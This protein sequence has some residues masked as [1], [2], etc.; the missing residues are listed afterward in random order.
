MSE[1]ILLP[2]ELTVSLSI[3]HLRI[4]NNTIL[5]LYEQ[6]RKNVGKLK[7]NVIVLRILR[8]CI[9]TAKKIDYLDT[10]GIQNVSLY[11]LKQVIR[12][13]KIPETNEIRITEEV[14]YTIYVM[15]D[16]DKTPKSCC[17]II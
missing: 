14:M 15:L 13:L 17:V 10:D 16:H 12:H 4:V 7:D 8:G 11:M 6:Y 1:E 2:N 9:R 3:R 5:E